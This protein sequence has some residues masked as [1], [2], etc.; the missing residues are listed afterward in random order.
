MTRDSTRR[1]KS[2]MRRSW[3][4]TLLFLLWLVCLA[5]G[6]PPDPSLVQFL[7][8]VRQTVKADDK[9]SLRR[10]GERDENL[11]WFSWL[12]GD[13]QLPFWKVDL[14]P[15]PKGY[16][17]PSEWWLIFHKFQTVEELCDRVHR[18]IKTDQGWR[19]GAEVAESVPVPFR[20]EVHE[21]K[22]ELFPETRRGTFR[23]TIQVKRI[24]PEDRALWMRLNAPYRVTAASLEGEPVPV[25]TY[26]GDSLPDPPEA[27]VWLGRA[28]GVLW[29]QSAKPLPDK[30]RLR[31]EYEGTIWFPPNDRIG[32]SYCLLCSYWYPH[33]GRQPAKHQVTIRAPKGWVAIG[34]GVLIK[35]ES[36]DTHSIATWRN[37]LPVCFFSMVAGPYKVG[38]EARSKRNQRLIRRYQLSVDENRARQVVEK[39]A[40]AMDFFEERFGDFPYPHYYI[41]DT[42]DCGH[43]G[44][45]AY[46]FTFLEPTITDWACTHELGHTWWGGIVPNTYLRSIWNESMTQYSDSILLK[47]NEDGSLEA[48]LSSAL[49]MGRTVPIGKAYNPRDGVHAMAGYMRG[50]YVLRMLEHELGTPTMLQAMRTFAQKRRGLASEWEDFEE[51]VQ[52]VTG[53]SYHWFFEQ[54]IYTAEFPTLEIVSAEQRVAS[55]GGYLIQLR[56][57]QSGTSKPFRLRLPFK[58]EGQ[59][60]ARKGSASSKGLETVEVVFAGSE[61]VVQLE[62]DFQVSRLRLEPKG[63]AIL[64]KPST[65][66]L[67]LAILKERK[68]PTAIIYASSEPALRMEAE[69]VAAWLAEQGYSEVRLSSDEEV[70]LEA[71][72]EQNVVLVGRADQNAIVQQWRH[73][74]KGTI[75][76]GE[77]AYHGQKARG[78]LISLQNHPQA[79]DRFVLWLAATAKVPSMA[80]RL[81][82]LPPTTAQA[83][84]DPDGKVLFRQT[85]TDDPWEYTFE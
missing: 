23:D 61:G 16:G 35:E 77:I 56:L 79:P 83:V 32:T 85:A 40:R 8:N 21:L 73:D 52:E 10:L 19:L 55:K 12:R 58:L 26:E 50:A 65:Y 54:W 62:N 2:L 81:R 49:S 3:I 7:Q 17:D 20:I 5:W 80:N 24:A 14:F 9:E 45:E 42:P 46:S 22:V 66:L 64:R 41:V 67:P 36:T 76:P 38:A 25:V 78:T 63:Y 75:H 60:K 33:I 51:V 82:Q 74:L 44:L 37:D 71:L 43:S 4:L 39:T 34:Q 11:A 57:R 72:S 18:L 1:E 6:V 28:G 70:D 15:A 29:L 84:F 47:G 48:G 59:R 30:F 53:H 27:E 13:D 68:G 69:A 31:L